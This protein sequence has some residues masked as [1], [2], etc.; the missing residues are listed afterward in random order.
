MS[1]EICSGAQHG[2]ALSPT[3]FDCIIDW[4]LGQALQG[5]TGVLVGTNVTVSY[6]ASADDIVILSNR[7]REMQDL[8]E[9]VNRHVAAVAMSINASKT[10]VM[11]ALTPSE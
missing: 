5:Y 3:F 4:I 11:Q 8:F 7:Y 6:L 9:A 10:K 1:F 2:C